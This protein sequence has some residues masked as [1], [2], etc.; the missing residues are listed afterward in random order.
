METQKMTM[1]CGTTTII[2]ELGSNYFEPLDPQV[3]K[4]ERHL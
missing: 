2:N 3:E 4:V 1:D